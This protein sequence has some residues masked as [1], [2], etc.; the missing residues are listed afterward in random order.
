MGESRW[1]RFYIG[2]KDEQT[3][4]FGRPHK[5][6]P[7]H[8]HMHMQAQGSTAVAIYYGLLNT[9]AHCESNQI[10]PSSFPWIQ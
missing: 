1:S 7:T 3:E 9:S 8:T 4:T 5:V 10:K 2:M 6:M